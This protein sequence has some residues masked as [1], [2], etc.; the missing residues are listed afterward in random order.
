MSDEIKP[1]IT[2]MFDEP[3]LDM[4]VSVLTPTKKVEPPPVVEAQIKEPAFTVLNKT[5]L[6]ETEYII[7]NI[8]LEGLDELSGLYGTMDEKFTRDCARIRLGL[9]D[10]LAKKFGYRDATAAKADGLSF[11]LKTNHELELL[12]KGE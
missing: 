10:I 11:K 7:Y 5:S 4:P 8:A 2:D 9:L 1:V 12:K 3:S 6:T